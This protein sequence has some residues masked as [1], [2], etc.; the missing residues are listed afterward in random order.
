LFYL[1][2]YQLN[3]GVEYFEQPPKTLCMSVATKSIL[4][5]TS[6]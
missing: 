5:G 2:K 3:L 1:P 4:A 6:S